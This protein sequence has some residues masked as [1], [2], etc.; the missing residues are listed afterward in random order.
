MVTEGGGSYFPI[1]LRM[2]DECDPVAAGGFYF[3]VIRTI[4]VDRTSGWESPYLIWLG[5]VSNAGTL[6]SSSIPNAK[7]LSANIVPTK[8]PTD[9]ESKNY[10][11]RRPLNRLGCWRGITGASDLNT[12]PL[13]TILP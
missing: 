3:F 11:L 1:A 10:L 7:P 6:G 12:L 13:R 9:P 8:L 4:I 5:F 2:K